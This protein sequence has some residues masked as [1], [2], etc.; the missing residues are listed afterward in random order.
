M[1]SY[2]LIQY[3]GGKYMLLEVLTLET[4]MQMHLFKT[5]I[6]NTLFNIF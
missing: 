5:S 2:F 4:M 1:H 6:I 3:Q